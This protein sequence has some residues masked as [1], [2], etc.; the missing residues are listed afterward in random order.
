MAGLLCVQVLV[1]LVFMI[2]FDFLLFLSAVLNPEATAPHLPTCIQLT[3]WVFICTICKTVAVAADRV[4]DKWA[5]LSSCA[6]C[7][8]AIAAIHPTLTCMVLKCNPQSHK[9]CKAM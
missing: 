8:D 3:A 9:G 2:S 4:D 5:V 1:L 7:G 6:C